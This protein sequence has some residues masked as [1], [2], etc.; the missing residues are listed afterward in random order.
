MSKTKPSRPAKTGAKAL[1]E[2]TGPT[3]GYVVPKA[4]TIV[5]KPKKKKG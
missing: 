5:K 3:G 1:G 4:N 2:S